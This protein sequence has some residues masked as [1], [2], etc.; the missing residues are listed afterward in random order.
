MSRIDSNPFRVQGEVISI[1]ELAKTKPALIV[2]ADDPRVAPF[3]DR[4]AEIQAVL[5]R[6]YPEEFALRAEANP[7]QIY[8]PTLT[9]AQP[10]VTAASAKQKFS[11]LEWELARSR[12]TLDALV[13]K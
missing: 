2:A 13:K 1:A 5:K 8:E 6:E 4:M 11:S 7:G 3:K 9:L 12:M 10:E